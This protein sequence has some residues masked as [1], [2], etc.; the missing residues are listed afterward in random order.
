M[1]RRKPVTPISLPRALIAPAGIPL[2]VHPEARPD[3]AKITAI[4]A[5]HTLT[6]LSPP[7][8]VI[9]DRHH[10]PEIVTCLTKPCRSVL[11]AHIQSP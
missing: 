10:M 7:G 9:V 6:R 11:T 2:L 8:I 5:S 1:R 3:R 4:A